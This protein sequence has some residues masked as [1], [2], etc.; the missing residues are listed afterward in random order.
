MLTVRIEDHPSLIARIEPKDQSIFAKLTPVGGSMIAALTSGNQSL[1][2][3]IEPRT[4]LE[5]YYETDNAAG[6]TTI[7]IGE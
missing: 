1:R 7:I 2:A 6:G 3:K 4:E 5:P